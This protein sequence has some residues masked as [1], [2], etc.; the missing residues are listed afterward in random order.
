MNVLIIEDE[1]PAAN[2]L[3]RLIRDV[4]PSY[5]ILDEIDTVRD[6]VAWLK[7]NPAPDLIML[8]IHLADGSSFEI[9]E[10]VTVNSPI[11]FTTAYDEYA[12]QGFK[13]NSIDY[14]LKPVK[15]DDLKRAI[16]KLNLLR[17]ST[18]EE[19]QGIDYGKL[20][21]VLSD[22]NQKTNNQRI[23]LRFG[24]KLKA[25][26]ISD[27]A[28]FYTESKTTL[29]RTFEGKNY[30]IDFTLDQIEEMVDQAQFFRIHRSIIVNFDAIQEMYTY[31]KARVKLDL[32]PAAPFEAIT[33][34]ERS[35]D[36]KEWLKGK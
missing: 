36:F 2:R 11:I 7:N 3:K 4:A 16:S 14:L 29:M 35:A 27:I 12:V 24:G 10:E 33:S 8:D 15:A 17:S 34:S 1:R 22:I 6:A 5:T 32:K 26:P 13:L 23:V 9:F 20:A 30:G 25:I 28:Y 31:S 19:E 18:P 21:K